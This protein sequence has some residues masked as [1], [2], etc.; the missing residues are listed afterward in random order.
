MANHQMLS[1]RLT[2]PVGWLDLA[3]QSGSL[4]QL[5]NPAQRVAI[6]RSVGWDAALGRQAGRQA[7]RQ[8]TQQQYGSRRNKHADLVTDW[9]PGSLAGCL[10]GEAG[11]LAGAGTLTPTDAAVID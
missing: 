5:S 9:P 11:W 1:V 4:S 7:F 2:V 3:G 10:S 8:H 6:S